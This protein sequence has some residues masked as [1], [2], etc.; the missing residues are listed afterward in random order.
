MESESPPMCRYIPRSYSDN[1]DTSATFS[2]C[3]SDCSGE[4]PSTPLSGG[5]TS[6]SLHRILLS[7]ASV[8]SSDE[9]ID[10]LV[11]ELSSPSNDLESLR[12][13]TTELRLLAKHNPENRIR[14]AHAGAVQPLISFLSHQDPILQENGVTALLNLSLCDENKALIAEA[15]AIRPLVRALKLGPTTAA[16]EN[17]ACALLRLSQLDGLA[18]VIGRAGAIPLLINLLETSGPRGKKDALTTLYSLCNGSRENKLQ[19]VQH[20]AVRPLL[21][22]MADSESGMVDKA[23]FVLHALVTTSEGRDAAVQEGGIPVLV[24]MVEAGT[25]RQKEIATLAL[26][27]ICEESSTY[28]TMVA[29]EGAIPPLVALSQS[30]NAKSK[31]K[32]KAEALIELLRQPRSSGRSRGAAE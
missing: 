23:A 31:S 13:A 2:D 18:T 12:R 21:E 14:I 5:T 25:Q 28:R 22:L 29:R 16:R 26:L 19:A 24:E 7:C 6:A 30:S 32:T 10:S 8:D 11:A 1:S 3:N 4:F 15:G 9:L 27:Q 17:A 20:G